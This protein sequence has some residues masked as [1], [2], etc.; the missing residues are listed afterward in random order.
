MARG[1]SSIARAVI[2]LFRH[3]LCLLPGEQIFPML[4][5]SILGATRH[6]FV[7]GYGAYNG[8]Y[9]VR[10][11]QTLRNSS[12]SHTM[13]PTTFALRYDYL[14]RNLRS[15]PTAS[16]SQMSPP[17]CRN[18]QQHRSLSRLGDWSDTKGTNASSLPFPKYA[19][20][21]LVHTCWS[22]E[23]ALTKQPCA[24]WPSVLASLNTWKSV[25]FW[26]VI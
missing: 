24:N 17:G 16:P 15:F 18:P 13:K 2:T 22:W 20:G 6:V 3:W 9:S 10:S 23:A 26:P 1:I 11:L 19:S 21:F 7:T 14:P 4:S 12:V 5:H 25:Q 8:G